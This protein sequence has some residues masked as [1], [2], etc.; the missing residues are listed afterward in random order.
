MPTE[1]S[2]QTPLGCMTESASGC[3]SPGSALSVKHLPAFDMLVSYSIL[4]VKN[5]VL[6]VWCIY[7][8]WCCYSAAVT[9]AGHTHPGFM[10]GSAGNAVGFCGHKELDFL[11]FAARVEIVPDGVRMD[12]QCFWSRGVLIRSDGK[13]SL[14]NEEVTYLFIFMKLEEM[15]IDWWMFHCSTDFNWETF[16]KVAHLILCVVL[17]CNWLRF[18][19]LFPS[20]NAFLDFSC[21]SRCTWLPS[22]TMALGCPNF[23]AFIAFRVT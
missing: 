23:R 13:A 6:P 7:G 16:T 1:L 19:E 10:C 18:V 9:A 17:E 4:W 14:L 11:A 21:Q 22:G 20:I 8:G 15:Q 5:I 12:A 3:V 2:S